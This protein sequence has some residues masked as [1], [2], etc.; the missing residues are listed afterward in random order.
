MTAGGQELCHDVPRSVPCI[1]TFLKIRSHVYILKFNNKVWLSSCGLL[2]YCHNLVCN[3]PAAYWI[4]VMKWFAAIHAL[5]IYITSHAYINNPDRPF[6]DAWCCHSCIQRVWFCL[7]RH[8]TL[9]FALYSNLL[10]VVH[11]VLFYIWILKVR[12]KLH[13]HSPSWLCM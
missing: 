7:K 3:V 5:N 10:E 9:K 8:T 6:G 2:H 12:I 4:L 13:N 1:A 11:F